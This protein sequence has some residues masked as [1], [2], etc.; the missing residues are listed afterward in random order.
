MQYMLMLHVSESGWTGLTK[1][2][3]EQGMA[4]YIAYSEALAKA[5]ALRGTNALLP[6]AT[7]KIV[8]VD[9]VKA[10][11]MDGPYADSKEQIGGYYLIEVPDLDAAVEWAARCPAAGH[12][13][14]E[15]RQIREI[16]P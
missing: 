4:A 16:Q 5:G 2:Q 3:Q 11:V 9:K 15:V 10:Q 14:V 8:R 6:S 1:V 7:A 13:T 12:G